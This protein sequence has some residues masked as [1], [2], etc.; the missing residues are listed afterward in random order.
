MVTAVGLTGP[1]VPGATPLDKEDVEQLIPNALT[2]Q[3]EL[4]EWEETNIGEAREWLGRQRKWRDPLAYGFAI[5]LHRRMFYRTWQWAGTLRRR[6]AS[7]GVDPR[8]IP[9]LLPQA[10]DNAKYQ[11]TLTEDPLNHGHRVA[12][13]LHHRL[14]QIHPFRNGNGRHA[15]LL[16]DYVLRKREAEPFTWGRANLVNAGPVRDA[17]IAALRAADA[18]DFEPLYVFVRS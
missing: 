3:R 10:L 9:F 1:Q 11:F 2:T 18:V 12:A 8:S 13:R 5:E 15:R 4:N 7:V 14:V 6:E 17:Y 16:V